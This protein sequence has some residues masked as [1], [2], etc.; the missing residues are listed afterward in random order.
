MLKLKGTATNDNL[1]QFSIYVYMYTYMYV[2]NN[3]H[4]YMNTQIDL[5]KQ[6]VP[7]R[8]IFFLRKHYGQMPGPLRSMM[9][10]LRNGCRIGGNIMLYAPR[11][12]LSQYGDLKG[13]DGTMTNLGKAVIYGP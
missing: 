5:V 4:T 6:H 12:D 8:S 13:L 7:I 11:H 2:H 10:E 3:T 1:N 9:T